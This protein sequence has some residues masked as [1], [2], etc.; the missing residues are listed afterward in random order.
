VCGRVAVDGV[1]V[2]RT[3]DGLVRRRAHGHFD[4]LAGRGEILRCATPDSHGSTPEGLSVKELAQNVSVVSNECGLVLDSAKYVAA[5]K[6]DLLAI[7]YA[8]VSGSAKTFADLTA[9]S[10]LFEGTIIRLFRRL[11]EMCN[12]L[13]KAANAIGEKTLKD[14]LEEGQKKMKR[15]IMFAGSLYI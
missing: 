6:P 13:I 7:T 1:P 12:Q 8:W 2:R 10:D 4:L 9:M 14:R 5:F 11:D 3:L 15:G